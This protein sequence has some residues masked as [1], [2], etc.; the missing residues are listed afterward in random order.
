MVSDPCPFLPQAQAAPASGAVMLFA[1]SLFCHDEEQIVPAGIVLPI[2]EIRSIPAVGQTLAELVERLP[3]T[4]A[5]M[6]VPAAGVGLLGLLL[7]VVG[8][9]LRFKR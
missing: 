1:A 9:F 6:G 5:P 2:E 7:C 8:L 3:R 4:G